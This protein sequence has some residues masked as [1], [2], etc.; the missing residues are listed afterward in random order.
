M[1][2]TEFNVMRGVILPEVKPYKHRAVRANVERLI[3][4]VSDEIKVKLG[5]RLVSMVLYGSTVTEKRT[6]WSDVDLL[7][8][9]RRVDESTEW[10]LRSIY[11]EYKN[12][13]SILLADMPTFLA[14]VMKGD[15]YTLH[16]V[17]EG[18]PILDRLGFFSA[19]KDSC[20]RSMIKPSRLT[21]KFLLERSRALL[22]SAELC[23]KSCVDRL[24][25]ALSDLAYGCCYLRGH[26]T[27]TIEEASSFLSEEGLEEVARHLFLIVSLRRQSKRQVVSLDQL[28]EVWDPIH[29]LI[30]NLTN[31]LLS[32]EGRS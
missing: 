31:S 17:E 23:L 4:Q 22:S 28:M 25:W 5:D 6:E 30:T 19:I 9:V 1:V 11:E 26:S 20:A 18:A 24:Y 15:P 12:V 7:V 3:R 16:I 2:L 8:I 14:S 13:V 21:G 27:K 32:E 10:I 29:E